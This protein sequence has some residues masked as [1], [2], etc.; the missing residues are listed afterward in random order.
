MYW[1][2]FDIER[3]IPPVNPAGAPELEEV[4]SKC[5]FHVRSI[6]PMF[7]FGWPAT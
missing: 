6:K 7:L 2:R 4:R 5:R 1:L 3:V